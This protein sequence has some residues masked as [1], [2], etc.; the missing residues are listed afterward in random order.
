MNLYLD[1]SGSR[2]P[3]K[4][5]DKSRE[6]RDWFALGGFLI[7]EEDIDAVKASHADI[8]N[9][10]RIRHPFHITDM[11]AKQKG[12]SWLGRLSAVELDQFW[13][14]YVWFLKGLP[15]IGHGCVIDRP[16][17]IRRG[18][19]EKYGNDK[20]LLCRSAFDIVV[21]RAAKIARLNERRLRIIFEADAGVNEIMKG[22]F[23]NLKQHGL[24]FDQG[25]SQK[26]KPLTQTDF[27]NLL[28]DIEYKDKKNSLIQIADSFVYS[29]ARQRY[30]RHFWI[31]QHLRDAKKISNFALPQECISE[32]GIK[33]YCFD[34]K[35]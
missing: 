4:K 28:Y 19:L 30:D 34:P 11:L 23:K 18:Y 9:K 2:H 17:Y 25:K 31:Y 6:G 12:F 15:V 22:Y 24:A 26:Y 5:A 7:N 8:S 10:W 35:K 21:E 16:G 33:Y 3:D 29:I 32:M 14:D 13:N 20:W 27:K 1:D